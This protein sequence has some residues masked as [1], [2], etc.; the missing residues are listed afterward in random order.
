MAVAK[1][2]NNSKNKDYNTNKNNGDKRVN[3]EVSRRIMEKMVVIVIVMTILIL[4][5]MI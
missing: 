2:K 1:L 5:K 4:L 3:F